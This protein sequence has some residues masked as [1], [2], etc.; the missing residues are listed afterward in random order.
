MKKQG[1]IDLINDE[2]G[3]NEVYSSKHY[4]YGTM[5]VNYWREYVKMLDDEQA[6][7]AKSKE[8]MGRS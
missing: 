3:S 2:G 8:A 4:I 5:I 6:E 1:K 7:A